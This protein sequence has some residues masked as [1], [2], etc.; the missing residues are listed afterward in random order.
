MSTENILFMCV[1]IYEYVYIC[2][3]KQGS[4]LLV[5]IVISGIVII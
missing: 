5:M 2:T 1:Y 4:D 3:I